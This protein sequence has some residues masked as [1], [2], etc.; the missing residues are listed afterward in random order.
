M[1]QHSQTFTY[2]SEVIY[3]EITEYG[4][5]RSFEEEEEL[6]EQLKTSTA[7]EEIQTL[8]EEKQKLLQEIESHKNAL[9]NIE[10]RILPILGGTNV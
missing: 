9:R 8:K 7:S 5:L 4:I 2:M 10:E 6:Q 1:L 3:M